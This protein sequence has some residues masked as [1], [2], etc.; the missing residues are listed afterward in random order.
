MVSSLF[1]CLWVC[2]SC[3]VLGKLCMVLFYIMCLLN[4]RYSRN[5]CYVWVV[6]MKLIMLLIIMCG[7]DISVC[8]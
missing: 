5:I 1:R 3:E 6:V 7:I 2:I 8:F 4:S